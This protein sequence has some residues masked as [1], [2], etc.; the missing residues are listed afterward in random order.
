MDIKQLKTFICVAESGSLSRAS[1]RMR[2]AQPALSRQIKLLEHEVGVSLFDRHVRGM[3]LTEAG[4]ELLARV[5][6]PIYQLEQSI[7]DIKS[8]SAGVTGHVTLGVLPT[9]S[10]AFSVRLMELAGE[11]SPGV[12]LRLREAYSVNL[13]EW[14]QSGEIDAAFLYGP[15]SA[16]HL[17][18]KELLTE[19]IVMLSPPGSLGGGGKSIHI[20]EIAK[21][22]LALPSRPYG[23][24]VI[25]DRIAREAGVTL[26]AAFEIDSFWIIS[27]MVKAGHCHAFMPVSSVAE[28][29]AAGLIELRRIRPGRAIRQLILAQPSDRPNTRATDAIIAVLM[30]AVAGMIRQGDWA[31]KPGPDLRSYL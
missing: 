28:E 24:R 20:K 29:S 25:V 9:I 7:Y 6:G 18:T 4:K 15:A 3:D 17:R 23:P 2:I 26:E 5:S 12:T 14:L 21:L 1:D 30:E 19:D 11:R 16:Y 22:P 8:L 13:V 31:A 27:A 10:S